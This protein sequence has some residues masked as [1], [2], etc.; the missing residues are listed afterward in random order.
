MLGWKAVTKDSLIWNGSNS[1]DTWIESCKPRHSIKKV[2]VLLV[3]ASGQ[4][5]NSGKGVAASYRPLIEQ[6]QNDS[7][8]FGRDNLCWNTKHKRTQFL[9]MQFS[10]L[11]TDFYDYHR[12]QGSKHISQLN[13]QSIT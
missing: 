6:E 10:C 7:Y 1:S 2:F 3:I 9:S 5:Q 11:P 13:L 8:Y 12:K 4:K